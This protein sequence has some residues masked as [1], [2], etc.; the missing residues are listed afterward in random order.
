MTLAVAASS[1]AFLD[2]PARPAGYGSTWNSGD[3][4]RIFAAWY[5]SGGAEPAYSGFT[6]K[7]RQ[8]TRSISGDTITCAWW[9]KTAGGSE[10]ATYSTTSG[11]P[12]AVFVV[13][14]TGGA[15]ASSANEGHSSTDNGSGT[16]WT[17]S[18]VTA[19]VSDA[20]L[21]LGCVGY[22]AGATSVSGM[23]QEGSSV[24]VINIWKQN[25]GSG[26]T[27]TR[28]PAS[29]STDWV[30]VMLVVDGPGGGGGGAFGPRRSLLGVGRRSL[31]RDEWQR[32]AGESIYTRRAA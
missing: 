3:E 11:T 27:G 10:P 4:L 5:M 32:D 14:I 1:S 8:G 28:S 16:T 20:L 29:S 22:A 30:T 24:D 12:Y 25:V 2:N 13:A 18:A 7:I 26:S 9:G 21:L 23:T 19:N 6:T 31:R 17:A 15:Q